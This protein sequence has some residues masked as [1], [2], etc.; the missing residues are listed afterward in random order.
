MT[1]S[2]GMTVHNTSSGDYGIALTAPVYYDSSRQWNVSVMIPGRQMFTVWH[3]TD[4]EMADNPYRALQIG[5]A[6]KVTGTHG[7]TYIARVQYISRRYEW[8][9][10]LVGEQEYIYDGA[11]LAVMPVQKQGR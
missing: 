5:D 4:I 1:F 11:I 9:T 7:A 8:L 3:V 2:R 10:I 6:I